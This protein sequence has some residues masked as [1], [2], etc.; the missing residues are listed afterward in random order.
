MNFLNRLKFP[1]LAGILFV[2]TLVSCEQD[3]TT[4]GSDVIG[5]KPFTSEKITYDVFAYNKKIEAV[6][7][8]KLP[9]YQ[10]GHY[11]DPVYGKT[12]AQI[13]SQVLLTSYN[14][15][16][17]D[18]TQSFEVGS[19]DG[20][21]VENEKID[22]V[23]LY[24]PY[25]NNKIDTDSDGVIDRLDEFPEDATNDTDGDGVNNNIEVANSTNPLKKDTDGDG[26]DDGEDEDTVVDR[27]AKTYRL[28]SIYY[29]NRKT[30]INTIAN[31]SYI[32]ES[33]N[34]K[35]QRSTYFLRDLDPNANFEESQ[36]YYSSQQFSP[37]F[38]QEEVFYDGT[39]V[40][41]NKEILTLVKEDD[42]DTDDVDE[43]GSVESRLDPGIYV[44][45]GAVAETF[46]QENLLDKEGNSELLSASNFKEFFRGVH[47][48]MP[49]GD[50]DLMLLLNITGAKFQVHYTYDDLV[51]D[52]IEKAQKTLDIGLMSSAAGN[53][54]NTFINEDYPT[55]ISAALDTGENAN[56]IY[57]KGGAGSYAEIKLFDDDDQESD[58]LIDQIKANKWIINE[59]NVVFY[60]DS[61]AILTDVIEPQRLYL[62]DTETNLP[63][64]NAATEVSDANTAL[65]SYLNYDGLIEKS[66]EKGVKYTIKITEYLN[67]III[68]DSIN[69]TLGLAIS[70]DIRLTG[71]NNTILKGGVEKDLPAA[72]IL[73]PIGT[74]LFGSNVSEAE[75]AKKL[76]LEIFY[77]E[78]N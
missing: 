20:A 12:E 38:T 46:F 66:G 29:D 14:P 15:T 31:P 32:G 67:D 61:D 70:P 65:G 39:F 55:E 76:K 71:I 51:D 78:T 6:Q 42:P 34:L 50:K 25:L 2:L 74:V 30:E 57:L 48:S 3:L 8:N 10:L 33:F 28:D 37:S 16:F 53:G 24:I 35:V 23:Y 5:G 44:K 36:E 41:N 72:P 75:E 77:T 22:S 49:S 68:R 27:F 1:A 9:V 21:I 69:H 7:T 4:I 43:E 54:V 13:T 62:Y 26:E 58:I 73:S 18:L 56:K 11:D 60:I 40:I 59:A 47:I 52:E 64:Y 19:E 17:G 63:L 45:L